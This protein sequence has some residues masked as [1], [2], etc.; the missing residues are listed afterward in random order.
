MSA[1]ALM[2]RRAWSHWH[3]SRDSPI[4][5]AHDLI[6]AESKDTCLIAG[7][8][9][10]A[11]NEIVNSKSAGIEYKN[12]GSAAKLL[13]PISLMH[14]VMSRLMTKRLA[15]CSIVL[16]SRRHRFGW[17]LEPSY[18]YKFGAGRERSLAIK[19]VVP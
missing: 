10:Q 5:P 12:V 4:T 14:K 15:V 17:Y 7:S 3:V 6:P 16:P 1:P 18:Q 8:P 13:L 11:C 2:L 19:A 9:T